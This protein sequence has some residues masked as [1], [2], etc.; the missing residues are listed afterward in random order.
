MNDSHRTVGCDGPVIGPSDAMDH[1]PPHPITSLVRH[2][3]VD[4]YK[5]TSTGLCRP[6][7]THFDW[8]SVDTY[9]DSSTD[10][11][12]LSEKHFNWTLLN[13]V[14]R[15]GCGDYKRK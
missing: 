14:V 13:W 8:T 10:L 12:R 11:C 2:I 5:H 1:R 7:E 9:S 4:I 3:H 6:S 15:K